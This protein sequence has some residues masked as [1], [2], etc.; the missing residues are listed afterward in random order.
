MSL[1]V[2]LKVK[3]GF[4]FHCRIWFTE[5]YTGAAKIAFETGFVNDLLE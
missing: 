5:G 4:V 3:W 1:S 2:Y